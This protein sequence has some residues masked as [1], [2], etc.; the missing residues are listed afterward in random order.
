[1]QHASKNEMT[2]PKKT[3]KSPILIDHGSLED[4]TKTGP[5]GSSDGGGT[6]GSKSS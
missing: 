5:N 1:M 3:Y 6:I 4:K 2:P